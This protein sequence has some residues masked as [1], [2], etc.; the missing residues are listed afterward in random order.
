M[1]SK[2]DLQQLVSKIAFDGIT[3]ESSVPMPKIISQCNEISWRMTQSPNREKLLPLQSIEGMSTLGYAEIISAVCG[4]L[5]EDQVYLNIG[6][7][8]GLSLVAG[9]ITSGCRVIGVDNFSQFGGP[10]DEF[11]RNYHAHARS[12]SEFHDVDYVK[13]MET[14]APDRIDFYFYDGPHRYDDQYRAIMLA[15]HKLPKGSLIMI[16]DTNVPEVREAT[17]AALDDCNR[18]YDVWLD[19]RTAHNK[20]PTFWNGLML[21]GV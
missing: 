20:H 1:I 18:S 19:I 12:N 15:N 13:Y 4:S 2:Q 21:L 8:K 6:C 14:S 3:P 16:D 9:L 17:I 10:K 5:S 11:L 7:Y